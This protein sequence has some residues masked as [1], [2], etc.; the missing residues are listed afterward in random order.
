MVGT[1]RRHTYGPNRPPPKNCQFGLWLEWRRVVKCDEDHNMHAY[2][3]GEILPQRPEWVAQTKRVILHHTNLVAR[4]DILN[5]WRT[6]GDLIKSI[7]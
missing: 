6:E 3:E 5:E 1:H 2:E 7:N 4:L